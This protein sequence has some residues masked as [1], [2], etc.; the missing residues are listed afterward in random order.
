MKTLAIASRKGGS[1]KT[2]ISVHIG[3]WR[4]KPAVVRHR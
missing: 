2:T 4:I 1:S 3:V